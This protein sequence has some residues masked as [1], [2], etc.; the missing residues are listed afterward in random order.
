[1][2]LTVMRHILLGTKR[3]ICILVQSEVSLGCVLFGVLRTSSARATALEAGGGH[4]DSEL[5]LWVW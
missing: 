2:H 4:V 5:G 1:M 3:K